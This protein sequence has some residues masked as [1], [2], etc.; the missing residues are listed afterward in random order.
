MANLAIV[1]SHSTNGVSAIHSE[2]LRKTTVRDLAEAF[3]DR[4][5]N[6]TNGV[7]PRRWLRLANPFLADTI[8]AAIGDSWITDLTKLQKLRPLANDAAFRAEIQRA[9]R[10]AK[11]RFSDW[12]KTQSETSVDPDTAFD[13]QIKRI[14]EYKRQLLNALRIVILYLRLRQ[15]PGLAVPPRTFFFAGKAA[16][17]YYLAKVIIKFINNLARTIESDPLTRGKLN[18]VFLPEY[19]VSLAERL[20]PA[21]DVS[22][23]ISTAGYEAS[24]TSNMKFMMNGALTLGTRDGSTIEMAEEAGEENLFL[25][26]LTVDDVASSR[27]WYSPYWHYQNEPETRAALDLIFSD[28]FSGDEPGIFEPLR[29]ALLTYG[30]FYM[31]LADLT[32]YLRADGSLCQ[33]YLKP[34]EWAQKVILNI[35]ASGKFSSDRA[36][37]EYAAEIWSAHPCPVR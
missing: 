19:N 31:H 25:F 5:N 9:K 13:C 14:H 26:G 1:G 7:T 2:L 18:V 17:A 33:L 4:F 16:P 35:A 15:N 27:P 23:Q 8:T 12:L 30:D 37:S 28:H 11:A 10:A 29:D 24:G 3:P 21:A 34:D 32:S 6:K 20:I 22:N 36:I